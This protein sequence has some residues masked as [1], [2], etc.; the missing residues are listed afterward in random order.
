MII[1]RT[2]HIL[3]DWKVK[4]NEMEKKKIQ[5]CVLSFA[6]ISCMCVLYMHT[7]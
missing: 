5:Y 4:S 6:F 1:T 2:F 7:K 3:H